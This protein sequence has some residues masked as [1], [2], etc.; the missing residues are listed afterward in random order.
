M[1]Q[2]IAA[3]CDRGAT[4]ITVSDRMV[5]TADLTLTFEPDTSKATAIGKAAVVSY[6]GH[7]ARTGFDC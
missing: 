3:I 6:V 1:T 5:S 4:V 2:L 7:N